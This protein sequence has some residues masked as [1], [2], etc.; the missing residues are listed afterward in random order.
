MKLNQQHLILSDWLHKGQYLIWAKIDP[1]R[2]TNYYPESATLSV[3]SNFMV[4]AIPVDYKKYS[5]V[6]KDAFLQDGLRN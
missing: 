2:I 6:L 1:T 4:Q 5:N 3:H